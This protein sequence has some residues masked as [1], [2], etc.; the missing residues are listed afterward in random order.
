MPESAQPAIEK[1]KTIALSF[2][3]GCLVTAAGTNQALPKA[4]AKPATQPAAA[5]AEA[6][7]GK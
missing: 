4:D 3:A 6:P 2:L 5:T 7:P 1:A